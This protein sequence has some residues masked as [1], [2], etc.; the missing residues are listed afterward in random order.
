VDPRTG[1]DEAENLA[2]LGFDVRIIQS[3]ASLS[4]D[5]DIRAIDLG[6]M[7]FY[8]VEHTVMQQYF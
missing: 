8:F 4:N 2:P 6:V 1:L 3:V 5:G 7:K